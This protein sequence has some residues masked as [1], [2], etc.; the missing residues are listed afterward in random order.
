MKYKDKINLI[1]DTI[2]S[3]TPEIDQKY[4]INKAVIDRSNFIPHKLSKRKVSFKLSWLYVIPFVLIFG[5]ILLTPKGLKKT[6]DKAMPENI[7]DYSNY[8]NIAALSLTSLFE[9][10]FERD[11]T[12]E[13][14]PDDEFNEGVDF[15][16]NY[17][18]TIELLH[19]LVNINS[20]DHIMSA[21]AINERRDFAF[22]S[23]ANEVKVSS[24]NKAYYIDKNNN[25]DSTTF[26]I[27][28]DVNNY[29]TLDVS[30]DSLNTFEI[31]IIMDNQNQSSSIIILNN[32]KIQIEN[33]NVLNFKE[34]YKI[35]DISN[36][37]I[38]IKY[39]K[40]NMN[41]ELVASASIQV[42][43]NIK[44]NMYTYKV[45]E[46]NKFSLYDRPR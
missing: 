36:Y 5:V 44:N 19:G 13:Y 12:I 33:T 18:P 27:T 39:E 34:I 22:E 35:E 2:T 11:K 43:I 15:L 45:S 16:N 46:K 37:S 38:Y 31:D 21:N 6:N 30:K 25:M 4:I 42:V 17:M 9:E 26:K 7:I 40:Y 32:K 1:K 28:A 41:E 3:Y 8:D 20:K 10:I 23:V 14:G 24:N 29:I